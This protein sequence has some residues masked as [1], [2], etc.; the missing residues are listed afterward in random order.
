LIGSEII[1][2]N[3]NNRQYANLYKGLGLD[4]AVYEIK[5]VKERKN[6]DFRLFFTLNETERI[7]YVVA[8]REAHYDTTK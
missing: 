2:V 3:K 6:I 5:Y 1:Y 8:I 7:F 4:E